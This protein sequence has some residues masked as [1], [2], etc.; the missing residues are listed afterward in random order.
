MMQ[1]SDIR[2]YLRDG[3]FEKFQHAI[4]C[5]AVNSPEQ[6]IGLLKSAEMWLMRHG[7]K[8][9]S[10]FCKV[11]ERLNRWNG[12]IMGEGK[13]ASSKYASLDDRL[14]WLVCQ[15]AED[16]LSQQRSTE[17]ERALRTLYDANAARA[18][19]FLLSEASEETISRFAHTFLDPDHLSNKASVDVIVRKIEDERL[20]RGNIGRYL[21]FTRKHGEETILKLTNQASCVYYIMYLVD[22]KQHSESR[23]PVLNLSS[24]MKQFTKLYNLIYDISPADL[25]RRFQRLLYR[26]DALGMKR[27]GR[28]RE[29]ISDI[30]KHLQENFSAYGESFFPYAMTA[31]SHLT[32]SPEKIVFESETQKL[33]DLHFY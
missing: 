28:E 15:C 11:G 21:I 32:V 8:P 25:I 29:C 24:N 20:T 30:R 13:W 16:W 12:S 18:I 22:R 31:H 26:E 5:M 14:E 23:L 33:L 19:L 1:Q 17:L 9:F 2:K 3:S 4:F 27:V 6:C 10:E 7:G